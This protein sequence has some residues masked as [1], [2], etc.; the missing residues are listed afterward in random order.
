MRSLPLRRRFDHRRGHQESDVA[1][2]PA[3]VTISSDRSSTEPEPEAA[4][5][6]RLLTFELHRLAEPLRSLLT[7]LHRAAY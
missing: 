6:S 2:G 1:S 5:R 3:T 7:F 4:L